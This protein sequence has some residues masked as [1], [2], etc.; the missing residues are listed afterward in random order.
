MEPLARVA[1]LWR[2]PVK[3]MAGERLDAAPFG[4]QGVAGDRRWAFAFAGD[5]STFP[6]FTGRRLSPLVTWDARLSNPEDPNHSHVEVRAPDGAAWDIADPRLAEELARACGHELRL[7]HSNRGCFDA[8]P[9]SVLG[10]GTVRAIGG[11]AGHGEALDARRFRPN[12]LVEAAPFAEE[13]WI[14]ATLQ[15]GE[16]DD[17]PVI[18]LDTVNERCVMVA[19]DPE[20]GERD[21]RVQRTVVQEHGNRTGVYATVVRP[22]VARPGDAVLRAS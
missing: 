6:W 18:R 12:V 17:A 4:W 11:E 15:L 1:A 9:V 20:T 21:P 10:T 5:T 14:G 16:G 13:E 8:F 2:Y 22:G 19:I 7:V 3:S